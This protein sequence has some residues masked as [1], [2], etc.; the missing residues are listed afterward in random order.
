[1]VLVILKMGH[2]I[3]V[4]AVRILV[5]IIFMALIVYPYWKLIGVTV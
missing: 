3:K 5:G 4:M 1:M 2:L